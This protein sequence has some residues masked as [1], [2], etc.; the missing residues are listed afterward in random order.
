MA[1][2]NDFVDLFEWIQTVEAREFP[3][4]PI[5]FRQGH[6]IINMDIFI[7]CL[8]MEKRDGP[9]ARLGSLQED[10][11]RLYAIWNSDHTK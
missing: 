5:P 9:R 11:R 10:L 8:R 4:P 1:E 6:K 7:Q 3:P 2:W